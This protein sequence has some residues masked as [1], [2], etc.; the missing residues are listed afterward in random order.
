MFEG[1]FLP[2]LGINVGSCFILVTKECNFMKV[3]TPLD[4]FLPL[5]YGQRSKSSSQSCENKQCLHTFH[6][7]CLPVEYSCIPLLQSKNHRLQP[8][9]ISIDCRTL[10]L[11]TLQGHSSPLMSVCHGVALCTC[12]CIAL[13]QEENQQTSLTNN[14]SSRLQVAPNGNKRFLFLF[15]SIFQ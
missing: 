4:F 13:R 5:G 7:P 1:F 14:N 11:L 3:A 2:S 6:S 15:S 10:H 9:E 8:L 12:S